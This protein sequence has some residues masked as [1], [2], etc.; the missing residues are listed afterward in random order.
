MHDLEESYK[1]KD[2]IAQSQKNQ[3]F[4]LPEIPSATEQDVI[5]YLRRSA[6]FAEMAAATERDALILS[7][8]EKLGINVSE[9]EW[10]EAGDVFRQKHKLW[11]IEE[12]LAWLNQQRIS[13][14]EW[15]EGIRVELLDKKLKEYLFGAAV[16]GEYT[17]NRDRYARVALSQILVPDLATAWK[18]VQILREE[19]TSFCALALEYSKGKKSQ[20]NGGFV[21]IRYVVEL[22]PEIAEAINNAKEGE[23]IGPVQSSL[24][25]HVLKVEKWFPIELNQEVRE[26]IIN[27]SFQLWLQAWKDTKPLD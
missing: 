3:E 13:V 11:G 16:D 24:G 6:K 8:C 5:A 23:I 26:Q 7:I 25:Y 27:V 2:L 1:T 15:S 17:L 9:E 19:H 20:E 4:S 14:E 18:I 21:G 22:L 12:T 10:Q